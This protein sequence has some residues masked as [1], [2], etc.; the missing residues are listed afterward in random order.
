LAY[1]ALQSQTQNI[2]RPFLMCIY[3]ACK[4]GL[5]LVHRRTFAKQKYVLL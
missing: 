4:A 5:N 2:S 1:I 3:E